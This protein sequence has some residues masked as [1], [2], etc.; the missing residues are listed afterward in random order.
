MKEV[1][2]KVRGQKG[3]DVI[4]RSLPVIRVIEYL[5]KSLISNFFFFLFL[6]CAQLL[7]KL[8][9]TINT[10][11]PTTQQQQ[12]NNKNPPCLWGPSIYKWSPEFSVTQSQKLSAAG[13]T[14]PLL[15]HEGN[16][17]QLMRS[18]QSNPIFPYLG[19]K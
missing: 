10:N 7:N 8:Q 4:T 9:P 16:H 14:M 18:V 3:G 15:E 6:L 12:L 11:Q 5:G 19:S 1:L 17:S 13:K 2:N